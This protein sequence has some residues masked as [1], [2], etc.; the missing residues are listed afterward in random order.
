VVAGVLLAAAALLRGLPPM[1]VAPVPSGASLRGVREAAFFMLRHRLLRTMTAISTWSWGAWVV[2]IPLGLAL[3]VAERRPTWLGIAGIGAYSFLIA[4]YGTANVISNLL[5]AMRPARP[6]MGLVY[7][8]YALLGLGIT[9]MGLI[10]IWAPDRWLLPALALAA[11]AGA[12]G[13]P[14]HDIRLATEIQTAGPPGAVAPLFRARMVCAWGAVLAAGLIAP[15]LFRWIGIAP[16]IA[17]MGLSLV[18]AA[19]LG[20]GILRGR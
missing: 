7:G 16:A 3:V 13:S 5:V 14:A 18:A 12:F 9:A 20:W 19:A 4:S 17:A 11:F 15:A 2:A 10:A 6:G 1:P 8:G